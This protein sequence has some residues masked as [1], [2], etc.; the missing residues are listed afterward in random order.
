[1]TKPRA[2]VLSVWIGVGGWTW[3]I[4]DAVV[5]ADIAY[6]ELM[7]RAPLLTSTTNDTTELMIWAMFNTAPLFFGSLESSDMKKLP[8]AWLLALG[9]VR[10][11]A[12]LCIASNM[13]ITLKARMAL[14]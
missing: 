6:L 2:I 13:L 12:S 4:L 7:N 14:G 3:P 5:R 8:L 10:C 11:G 9:S 1:M